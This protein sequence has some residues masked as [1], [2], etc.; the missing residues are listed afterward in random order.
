MSD[1]SSPSDREG[2][3]QEPRRVDRRTRRRQETIEEILDIAVE[4]MN[5]VGVNGLTLAEVARRL[6]VQTPSLYKYFPS[7]MSVYDALFRRGQLEH[8]VVL[9]EAMLKGEPGLDALTAG[10][11]ASGQW[12]L[13]HRALAQLLFWRPVPSFEPSPESVAPSIEI[14]S[15]QQQAIAIAVDRG[16]LG[17]EALKDAIFLVSIL[18]KG[19]LT[20]AF[21]YAPE[22]EWG[23]GRF[24]SFS[25]LMELV[26]AAYPPEPR[27]RH[28]PAEPSGLA[29]RGGARG[30]SLQR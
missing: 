27:G 24:T 17:P 8:L 25:C 20:Q 13:A 1:S 6:G 14:V 15:R 29:Q 2:G 3:A 21:A 22:L 19:V 23:E 18:F 9:R 26:P 4:V 10:L 11:E 30:G 28:V 16:E 5:E 12:A 7:L